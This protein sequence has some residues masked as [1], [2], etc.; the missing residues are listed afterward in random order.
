M[1]KGVLINRIKE[2]E[3]HEIK[4]HIIGCAALLDTGDVSYHITEWTY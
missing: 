4:K 1:T 2:G 3:D